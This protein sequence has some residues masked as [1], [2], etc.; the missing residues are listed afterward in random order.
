KVFS[1]PTPVGMYYPDFVAQMRGG[2]IR[3]TEVKDDLFWRA[4]ENEAERKARA[5]EEWC[6]V[7]SET[8]GTRWVMG[9]AFTSEVKAVDTFAELIARI[10]AASTS[11]PTD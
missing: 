6:R 8:G 4:E 10:D 9:V 11:D 2:E 3:V 7:Q 5:A 1:I